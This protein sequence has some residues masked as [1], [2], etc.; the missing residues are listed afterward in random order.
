MRSGQPVNDRKLERLIDLEI[1][2]PYN[3]SVLLCRLEQDMTSP[4]TEPPETGD[5]VADH[6]ARAIYFLQ[7]GREFLADGDL[8][9]ASEKGWGAAAHI[10]KAVAAS[11]GL[12][13][14]SHDEFDHVL[15]QASALAEK[16]PD[17][18]PRQRRPIPSPQLLQAQGV[19]E[20]RTHRAQPEQRS[21]TNRT[22]V[23]IV[24]ELGQ[25]LRLAFA[26]STFTPHP[27]TPTAL[28]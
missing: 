14:E 20:A 28:K 24:Q 13:Y 6:R 4:A 25:H 15:E 22:A 10:V 1:S 26:D 23:A 2:R 7:K 21:G 5:A 27:S 11:Y 8:H 9:Q 16:R 17:S 19:S 3:L 12:T 18:R